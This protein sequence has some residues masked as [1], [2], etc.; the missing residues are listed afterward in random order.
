ML[1]RVHKV[2][3]NGVPNKELD[4]VVFDS[5][6]VSLVVDLETDRDVIKC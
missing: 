1:E 4:L 2:V 6:S 3:E 5:P